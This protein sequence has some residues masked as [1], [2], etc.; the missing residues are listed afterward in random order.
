MVNIPKVYIGNWYIWKISLFCNEF[1]R[2]LIKY[3]FLW[4]LKGSVLSTRKAFSLKNITWH[5]YRLRSGWYWPIRDLEPDLW[6]NQSPGLANIASPSVLWRQQALHG[7]PGSLQALIITLL[8]S[9]KLRTAAVR[10]C[11]Y[12]VLAMY[13]LTGV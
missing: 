6:T 13:K 11:M 7:L 3:A 8:Q 12:A 5:L 4:T 10:C 2:T 9:T 1:G